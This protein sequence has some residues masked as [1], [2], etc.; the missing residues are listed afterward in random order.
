[1]A[2]GR[3]RQQQCFLSHAPGER[4]HMGGKSGDFPGSSDRIRPLGS[5]W[6]TAHHMP[7]SSGLITEDAMRNRL[8]SG[9]CSL[10]PETRTG[11]RKGMNALKLE[12]WQ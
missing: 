6:V 10:S 11:Q 4:A 1:M 12:Q 9:K 7:A 5:D 8:R 3:P 2:V